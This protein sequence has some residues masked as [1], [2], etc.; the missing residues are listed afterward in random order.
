M[1]SGVE[2][3]ARTQAASNIPSRYLIKGL[4]NADWQSQYEVGSLKS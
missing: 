1:P 3:N 4:E 2:L